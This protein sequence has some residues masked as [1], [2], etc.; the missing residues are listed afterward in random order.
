[1]CARFSSSPLWDSDSTWRGRALISHARVAFALGNES[2][3]LR[4]LDDAETALLSYDPSQ[5]TEWQSRKKN[6]LYLDELETF[7]NSI[8]KK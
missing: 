4:L 6:K 8:I 3:A 5:I 1:M 7:R 2:E